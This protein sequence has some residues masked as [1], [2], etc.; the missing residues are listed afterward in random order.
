MTDQSIDAT[1]VRLLD[2]ALCVFADKGFHK[3]SVR[4][5]CTRAQAN[6]AAINY[7]FGD[8]A[9]L[10]QQVFER[11]TARRL[12]LAQVFD[13]AMPPEAFTAYYRALLAPLAE[14]E[15]ALKV[16]RLYAREQLEP[17]GLLTD[18]RSKYL[19]PA[20]ARLVG[21]VCTHAGVAQPDLA[22]ERLAFS[23]VGMGAFYLHAQPVVQ[24]LRPQVL[25]GSSW[26][27]DLAAQLAHQAVVLL[28]AY[29]ECA[30]GSAQ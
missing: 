13:D 29:R 26:L 25:A 3:A 19:E 2:A 5:I 6:T 12:A 23:L 27:D 11:V 7:H 1:R 4:D 21:Y 8:K 9:Q 30:Q 10:Y 22:I 16:A 24:A 14:G 17:T 18:L 28:K 15:H 20:H